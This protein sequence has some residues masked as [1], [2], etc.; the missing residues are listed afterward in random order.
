MTVA[1]VVR[2]I[3]ACSIAFLIV[4]APAGPAHAQEEAESG[5]TQTGYYTQTQDPTKVAGAPIA[6]VL[7]EVPSPDPRTCLNPA[8]I[9]GATPGWPRQDN[10]VYTARIAG[11]DDTYGYAIPDLF[12]VPFGATILA[13]EFE[14]QVE[15]HEDVGTLDPEFDPDNPHIRLCL[16]TE[17]WVGIDS[18]PWEERPDHDCA[19]EAAIEKIGEEVRSEPD[20]RTEVERDRDIVIYKADLMPMAAVWA[21]DT[22]NNGIAFVPTTDAPDNYQIA[23]RTSA[24]APDAMVTRVTFDPPPTQVLDAPPLASF[25]DPGFDTTFEDVPSGGST[26]T[27]TQPETGAFQVPEQEEGPAQVRRALGTPEPRT[28]WW[29]WTVFPLGIAVMGTLGRGLTTTAPLATAGRLGPVGRLMERRRSG[30]EA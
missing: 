17:E 23:V 10:Y 18:G 29:V 12:V 9:I 8:L 24:Q 4:L 5:A 15:A 7:C 11:D 2:R 26:T 19:V 27:V 21:T 14:F 25:D 20:P 13:L 1:K 3:L 22:P 30:V 28:P 16:V 6:D